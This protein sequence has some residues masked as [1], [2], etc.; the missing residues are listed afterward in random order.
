[1]KIQ[2]RA[3]R[4]LGLEGTRCKSISGVAKEMNITRFQ[5]LHFLQGASPQISRGTFEAVCQYLLRHNIVTLDNVFQELF[6]V[7]PDSFWP[8]LSA[9]QQ[10][11]FSV[12]VRWTK[13]K[14][15]DQQVVADDAVLQS[16]MVNE[17]MGSAANSDAKTARRVDT[18]GRSSTRS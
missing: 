18:R 15:F 8:M 13:A 7:E 9:R 11:H 14:G 10:I 4:L 12:G 2:T 3:A 5:L 1:M 16:V 17:L 6:V